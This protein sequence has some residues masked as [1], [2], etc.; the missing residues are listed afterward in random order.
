MKISQPPNKPRDTTPHVKCL[1]PEPSQ[2]AQTPPKI[3]NTLVEEGRRV[4]TREVGRISC[5]HLDERKDP[6]SSDPQ[7]PPLTELAKQYSPALLSTKAH[8][9]LQPRLGE[10]GA[11]PS[12]PP[13]TFS[14]FFFLLSRSNTLAH[15]R[16]P[17]RPLRS[18]QLGRT[19]T[20]D[21]DPGDVTCGAGSE[22]SAPAWA[23]GRAPPRAAPTPTRT[24]TPRPVWRLPHL[25]R[26]GPC[27][28]PAGSPSRIGSSARPP[29]APR[30]SW[31]PLAAP[32]K[33]PPPEASGAVAP[34]ARGR[35]ALSPGVT[36]PPD[37]AGWCAP[38]RRRGRTGEPGRAGG[39]GRTAEST[40]ELAWEQQEEEGGEGEER[41]NGGGEG[42]TTKTPH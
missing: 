7:F 29:T 30:S 11:S 23:P 25:A 15:P 37:P 17:I 33:S 8:L 12:P 39:A 14:F 18:L 27:L 4:L 5:S 32:G 9:N 36:Q 35:G 34:P 42:G 21:L 1:H 41:G 13:R 16:G 2:R 26:R 3:L 22:G 20:P 24:R 10:P 19:R 40:Q 31:P 28:P 6:L 38:P